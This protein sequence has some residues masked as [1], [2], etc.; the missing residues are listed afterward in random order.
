[1]ATLEEQFN[2]Q[3]LNG[4]V[5][6]NDQNLQQALIETAVLDDLNDVN[7][8]S[9]TDGQALGYQASTNTWQNVNAAL[10][11]DSVTNAK[12]ANMATARVK[13]RATAGT[14]DPE[15]LVIDNDLSTVSASDDTIP[16]A[17]A[18]KDYVDILELKTR[19]RNGGL[20]NGFI[21][22]TVVSN[23]LI[24]AISTSPTSQVDPTATNP[25]YVWING[26][27]ESITSALTATATAGIN[28]FNSGSSEL[29]TKEI[30]YFVYAQWDNSQ[31]KV[32]V[33]F[34]RI[35]YARISTD[36]V[37]DNVSNGTNEKYFRTEGAGLILETT[38]IFVNIGRFA[39]TLSAG[40]GYT[41]SVP[42]FDNANLIQEPIYET[43]RLD[44]LTTFT[45]AGG[46]TLVGQ[47]KIINSICHIWF[48][49]S[50]ITIASA[51]QNLI[52]S[53][54]ISSALFSVGH[55]TINDNAGYVTGR[56]EMQAG[57]TTLSIKNSAGVDT[58]WTVGSGEVYLQH[59]YIIQ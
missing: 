24:V 58:N 35:P 6:V 2:E 39:A 51:N 22:V 20:L 40:A 15:D 59:Y 16:S 18:V 56:I 30:D 42:T 23:D 57:A 29:A 38:D 34:S 11:N 44:F 27:L 10:P 31:S 48:V 46:G 26:V 13:G 37:A 43:R 17:K 28:W 5:P 41:W 54:P 52:A 4:T 25:V 49:S 33:G 55:V 7:I 1:M 45:V 9:P 8:S 53:M 50:T 47:Y 36:F 21:R 32:N 19:I 12:L 3:I 14:G